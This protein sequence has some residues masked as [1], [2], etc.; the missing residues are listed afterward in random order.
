MAR[1]DR[2]SFPLSGQGGALAR[3][4]RLND[5]FRSKSRTGKT[6]PA[7]VIHNLRCDIYLQQPTSLNVVL[8]ANL[9]G[10]R[11]PSGE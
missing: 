11:P 3:P 10:Q 2:F 4:T 1:G 9:V 8:A 7:T 5:L 6:K